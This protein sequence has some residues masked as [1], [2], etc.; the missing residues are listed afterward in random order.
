MAD[1]YGRDA[2]VHFPPTN[3]EKNLGTLAI[4]HYVVGALLALFSCIFL[5]YVAMGVAMLCSPAGG[6]FDQP[7]A[8]TADPAPAVVAWVFIA[9]G[10]GGT[11]FGWAM[12]AATIVAGRSITARR[13]HVFCVVVGAL[14]CLWMPF[15]TI[16]GV[17]TLILLTKPHVKALFEPKPAA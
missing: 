12:A 4:F 9:L 2:Q 13:R 7:H 10:A 6:P 5:I 11:L 14:L 16:L 3:D 15:G 8:H 1:P 17:F